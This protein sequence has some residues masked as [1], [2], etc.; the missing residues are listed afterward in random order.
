MYFHTV[1]VIPISFRFFLS[2]SVGLLQLILSAIVSVVTS[3]LLV[4]R[5][6]AFWICPSTGLSQVAVSNKGATA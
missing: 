5:V 6:L 1:M 4:F 3:Q 2:C